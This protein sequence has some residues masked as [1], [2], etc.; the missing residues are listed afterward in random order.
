M[1]TLMPKGFFSLP[2]YH[3]NETLAH[4]S[5]THMNYLFKF[6]Q[7]RIK[8]IFL[9]YHQN[10][11]FHVEHCP[12]S[13]LC[14]WKSN[15]FYHQSKNDFIML[16]KNKKKSK[17]LN[18]YNFLVNPFWI[19][20]KACKWQTNNE[21]F[22]SHIFAFSCATMIQKME[23]SIFVSNFHISCSHSFKPGISIW[24]MEII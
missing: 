8:K 16:S 14:I 3:S 18:F 19:I 12:G 23:Y 1:I 24:Y 6:Q 20:H 10:F 21:Q 9:K 13:V 2:M 17:Y 22:I 11:F 7:I 15:I 5:I 4:W